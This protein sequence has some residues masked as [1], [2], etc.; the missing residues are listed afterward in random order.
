M[1]TPSKA[2]EQH[3]QSDC[4]GQNKLDYKKKEVCFECALLVYFKSFKYIIIACE[5]E[6][7]IQTVAPF[8]FCYHCYHLLDPLSCNPQHL[9]LSLISTFLYQFPHIHNSNL[10]HLSFA[11]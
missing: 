4:D 8:D 1:S 9:T 10:I 3:R 11:F 5:S 6:V 2:P 7:C